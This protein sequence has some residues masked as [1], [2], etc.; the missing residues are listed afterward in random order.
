MWRQLSRWY[1][2]R[3]QARGQPAGATGAVVVV[4]RFGSALNLNVHFHML[5]LDGVFVE[6]ADT[7]RWVK[8]PAPTTQEV[9]QL[10]TDLARTIEAWL[11]TQGYGSDDPCDEDLDDDAN[12]ALLAASVAGRTALGTRAGAK[13]RRLQRADAR[14]AV[15]SPSLPARPAPAWP[16]RTSGS[17]P[18]TGSLPLPPRR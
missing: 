9:Q 1:T 12:G 5:L 18:G 10:V 3:A 16:P 15:R 4:Q 7:V 13:V 11:D 2:L 8:V 17:V 14:L 6:D